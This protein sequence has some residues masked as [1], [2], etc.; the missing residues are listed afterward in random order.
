MPGKLEMSWF[1]IWSGGGSDGSDISHSSFSGSSSSVALGYV[2]Q[3]QDLSAPAS[4]LGYS[5]QVY[6]PQTRSYCLRPGMATIGDSS[7]GW[8]QTPH[9]NLMAFANA[10]A[11][12]NNSPFFSPFIHSS[13]NFEVAATPNASSPDKDF[14]LKLDHHNRE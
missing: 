8:Q 4:T 1:D 3:C 9:T 12:S 5:S 2:G 6:V 10:A 14:F 7:V 11:I 13:N